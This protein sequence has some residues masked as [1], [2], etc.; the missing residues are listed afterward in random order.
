MV[1]TLCEV[2][3]GT[4]SAHSEGEGRGCEIV[5][6]LPLPAE[7]FDATLPGVT[8]PTRP[9]GSR[10][11]LVVDDNEDS[12]RSIALLLTLWGHEARVAFEGHSALDAAR[13]FAPEV[14]LLDIGLPGLDGFELARQLR[15]RG[16]RALLVALTGYGRDED[17]ERSQ[18]AG[19]DQHLVK[20]IDPDELREI[21]ATATLPPAWP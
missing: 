1:R 3:G 16:V 19:F 6:R 14:F 8:A 2:H 15:A 11:V 13:D 5:V 18:D 17:R 7:P 4:V 12:A 10:K 21:L 9:R 20:P